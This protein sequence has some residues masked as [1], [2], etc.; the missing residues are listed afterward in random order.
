MGLLPTNVVV[1]DNKDTLITW[2]PYC[3]IRHIREE[4]VLKFLVNQDLDVI[5]DH[6]FAYITKEKKFEVE[7]Y[8]DEVDEY[9][10]IY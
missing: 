1:F 10:E 5:V 4:N 9:E 2:S 3:V 7:V 8:G 6:I